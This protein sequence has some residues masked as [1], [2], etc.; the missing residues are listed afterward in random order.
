MKIFN[1]DVL[2]S[3]I[4]DSCNRVGKYLRT[5]A[6]DMAVDEKYLSRQLNPLDDGAKLGIVDFVYVLANTDLKALDY[7][8]SIF[9]RVAI[10][11]KTKNIQK[12]E[13]W[14]MHIAGVSKEVG[15]AT[16]E[17]ARSLANDGELDYEEL[18]RCKKESYEALQALAALWQDLKQFE[19]ELGNG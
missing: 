15:E 7:I 18:K 10:P 14:L 4:H 3:I 2:L 8:N 16:A 5:L 13:D 11:M 19:R 9:D 1:P 17:I 6:N 12:R